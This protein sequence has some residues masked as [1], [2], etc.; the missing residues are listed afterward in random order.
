MGKDEFVKVLD[1]MLERCNGVDVSGY[2]F[3]THT[4]NEQTGIKEHKGYPVIYFKLYPQGEIDFM[5]N[6]LI[7][8]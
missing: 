2:A 5:P 8:L 1:D 4:E 7:E 3:C 6:P